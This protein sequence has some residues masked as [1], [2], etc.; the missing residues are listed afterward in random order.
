MN[1]VVSAAEPARRRDRGKLRDR[2]VELVRVRAGDLAPNPRNW[3]R[4]PER[5][6]RT[7]QN[8]TTLAERIAARALR[9]AREAAPA[10]APDCPD[11]DCPCTHQ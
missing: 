5:A 8:G 10:A 9:R 3:R 7:L 1:R 4:H 2:V 11:P 6:I